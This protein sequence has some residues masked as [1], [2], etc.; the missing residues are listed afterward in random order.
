MT[1]PNSVT[2]I[3]SDAFSGCSGLTS[4]TV[5]NSVTNIGTGAFSD[6]LYSSSG[7]VVGSN[8]TSIGTYAFASVAQKSYLDSFDISNISLTTLPNYMVQSIIFDCDLVIPPQVT[9]IGTSFNYGGSFKTVT[10]HEN[11]TSI[12]ASA[13]G[14]ISSDAASVYATT[15]MHFKRVSPPT[16]AYGA[17][18]AKYAHAGFT[19]YVPDQSV[20]AYKA[21]SYLSSFKNYIK[22]ESEM[23]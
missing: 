3:G 1:I 4:V 5:P 15:Y 8:L 21:V 17:I 18:G 12:A 13:F 16:F 9:S 2:S 10:I 7:I 22:G 23:P 11:V 14:T 6:C 19:I 20:S